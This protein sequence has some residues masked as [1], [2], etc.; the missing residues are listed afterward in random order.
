[1]A[2][3]VRNIRDERKV[4]VNIDRNV[5]AKVPAPFLDAFRASLC[6]SAMLGL[7]R[8]RG[9]KCV[10]GARARWSP[11][12][13]G[14]RGQHR[15]ASQRHPRHPRHRTIIVI[16]LSWLSVFYRRYL[17]F[18]A[19]NIMTCYFLSRSTQS[20]LFRHYC[21]HRFWCCRC[22]V[23]LIVVVRVSVVIVT[24]S[25]IIV[26]III[27]IIII[28]II[29]IIA[30]FT[31]AI[32]ISYHVVHQTMVYQHIMVIIIIIINSNNQHQH[33]HLPCQLIS[34]RISAVIMIDFCGYRRRHD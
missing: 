15:R 32:L 10:A 28:V 3:S 24:I 11:R 9:R 33:Y 1:M 4:S 14:L 8:K 5:A 22:H 26:V 18:F 16:E 34:K 12:K 21:R 13:R 19:F 20:C 7:R 25:I 31:T 23:A 6:R 17:L 27:A 2:V 30:F 29:I